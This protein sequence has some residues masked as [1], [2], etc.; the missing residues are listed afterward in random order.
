MFRGRLAIVL[1]AVLSFII[2]SGFA[3][4]VNPESDNPMPNVHTYTNCLSFDGID[5][6]V[7]IPDPE[8]EV[9]ELTEDFTIELWIYL[10]IVPLG[11]KR[12]IL[13]KHYGAEDNVGDWVLWIESDG[14]LNF[15]VPNFNV[16]GYFNFSGVEILD[17]STWYH[18]AIV[19]NDSLDFNYFYINGEL[20]NSDSVLLPINDSNEPVR[21]GREGGG[22]ST[23]RFPGKIVDVRFWNIQRSESEIRG[24]MC[25]NLEGIEV[26]LVGYWPLN[27]GEGQAIY[28]L[29]VNSNDGQLGSNPEPGGD[30]ND[31]LWQETLILECAIFNEYLPGDCNMYN[32]SWPPTVIGSDVTYLVNY[33][34]GVTANPPCLLSG[35][36]AAADVNGDCHVI[37]SDVTR[38]VN[39]FRGQGE[40]EPCPDFP[41]AWLSPADCP[42]EEPVGWPNCNE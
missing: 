9:L 34:R 6:W 35:F 25:Q 29:S 20:A 24:Y 39:F 42:A 38:L 30:Q 23:T 14:H 7:E 36:Y 33:F 41:P 31:P 5:D 19:R 40:I 3:E 27:E 8:S 4:T 26:G 11:T 22:I 18:I 12:V 32:G 10:D 37:G 17:D 2:N 13:S 28:D 16:G 21:L 1:I 15:Q